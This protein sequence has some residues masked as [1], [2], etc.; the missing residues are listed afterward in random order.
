[1]RP[2][3]VVLLSPLFDLLLCFLERLEPVGIETLFSEACIEAL[4][5]PI[6]NRLAG[7]YKVQ[8]HFVVIGPLIKGG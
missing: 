8:L 3:F 5:D 6:L 4:Y 7:S 2:D 1:M